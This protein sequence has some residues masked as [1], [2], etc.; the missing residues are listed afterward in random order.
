MLEPEKAQ[1]KFKRSIEFNC[2]KK[3]IRMTS[4]RFKTL[5]IEKSA[6]LG[7]YEYFNKLEISKKKKKQ[8]KPK[9]LN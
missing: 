4:Q 1:I 8:V 6:S 3:D 9:N 7:N 5:M 2:K